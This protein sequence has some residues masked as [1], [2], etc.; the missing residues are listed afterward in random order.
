VG[1]RERENIYY[2]YIYI[3]MGGLLHRASVSTCAGLSLPLILYIHMGGVLH[4]ASA[5][6]CAGLSQKGERG[7]RGQRR[8]GQC[9]EG[10][11]GVQPSNRSLQ[12]FKLS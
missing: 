3:Y 6:T 8:E 1:G 11:G 5:S 9:M 7:G 10:K 12:A 4:R 2:I